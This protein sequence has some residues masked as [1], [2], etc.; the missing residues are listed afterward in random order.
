MGFSVHICNLLLKYKKKIEYFVISRDF[1]YFLKK[2]KT[3]LKEKK[4]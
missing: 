1:L 2:I 4:T 3:F